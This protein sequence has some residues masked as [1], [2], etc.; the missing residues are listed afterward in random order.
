MNYG[1]YSDSKTYMRQSPREKERIKA[2]Q[3]DTGFFD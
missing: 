2:Q 3:K 1:G